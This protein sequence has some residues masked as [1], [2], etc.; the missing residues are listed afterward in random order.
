MTLF[1]LQVASPDGMKFEG[2]VRQLSVRGICGELAIMAGHI[3][4]VTA[5]SPGE[6]RIYTGKEG[7]ILRANASGGMLVVADDGVRL[8]SADFAWCDSTQ[9]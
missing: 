9:S 4:F 7:E 1:K 2:E 6:C 8:M 5:L 3:P